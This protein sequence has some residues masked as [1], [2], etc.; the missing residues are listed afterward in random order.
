MWQRRSYVVLAL[1]LCTS[2]SV[3]SCAP[4]GET[5]EEAAAAAAARETEDLDAV[6]SVIVRF[7]ETLNN[8]DM[9]GF[10]DLFTEDAIRMQ[11]NGQAIEG[12]SRIRL[13][14]IEIL[15]NADLQI[16][17]N[18]EEARFSGDI[19]VT[20]GTWALVVSPKDGSP[21]SDD[22]GKWLNLMERQEDGGWKITRNIWNSDRPLT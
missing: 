1:L 8:G 5:P 10:A 18:Q 22:V 21:P 11:P 3:Y 12:M 9:E 19:A 20:R 4:A 6:R 17:V 15:E 13:N 14:I 2:V 7:I 16:T